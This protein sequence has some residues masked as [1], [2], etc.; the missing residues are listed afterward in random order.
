MVSVRRSLRAAAI[1]GGAATVGYWS[2]LLSE[3]LVARK[4]IG[5]T[6]ER[7]PR[8]DG[9]YGVDQ[10]G[11]PV[12][13]L[14]LG[15]SA[16]VGY[17]MKRADLT[18]PALIGISLSHVLGQPVDV[19]SQAVVGATTPDLREQ[20]NIGMEHRPD[21]AVIIIG[22]NDVTHRVPAYVSSRLLSAAVKRLRD[23][24]AEVVVGTCPDL[25]TVRP[26]PQPLR[27]VARRKSRALA[28][29]QTIATVREGGRAVSLGG[30][31][32][33]IFAEMSDVM[34]GEDRFHPSATGY[35]NMVSVLVPSLAASWR[36]RDRDYAVAHSLGHQDTMSLAEAA[37]RAG[38]R[39]G[40]EVAREGRWAT[41]ILRRRR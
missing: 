10:G 28:R 26:I 23:A 41:T 33:P 38:R 11:T 2:V 9:V 25:G 37:E 40:T 31:L 36:E 7:P 21:L 12:R 3:V 19:R 24:G 13:V 34:F 18:P 5:T 15:D 14:V 32:G 30:L 29:R 1:G 22:A 20:I 39:D 27:W 6:D 17:G 4:V 8:A 35:A 16:A